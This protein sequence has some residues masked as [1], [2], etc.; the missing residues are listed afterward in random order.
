VNANLLPPPTPAP[1]PFYSRRWFR[2]AVCPSRCLSPCHFHR[3]Y[4]VACVDDVLSGF[5]IR[6][7]ISQRLFC[8]LRHRQ[9]FR[10]MALNRRGRI[11]SVSS[12]FRS[13][14]IFTPSRTPARSLRS[15][16]TA[17]CGRSARRFRA[18]SVKFLATP[19]SPQ[20]FASPICPH[21]ARVCNATRRR[22][23]Q[24]FFFRRISQLLRP[25]PA[26]PTPRRATRLTAFLIAD[27]RGLCSMSL[28]P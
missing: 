20:D 14:F 28:F 10:V 25:V 23:P 16:A 22:P 3:V 9:V 4:F 15:F 17:R 19:R 27:P 12:Y 21:R 24:S 7:R 1:V 11:S 6:C 8:P 5:R 26:H 18:G 13:L 2:A